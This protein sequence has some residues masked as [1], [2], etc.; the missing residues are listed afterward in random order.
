MK[1]NILLFLLLLC[2]YVNAQMNYSTKNKGAI[3]LF[4]KAMSAPGKALS[5][6]TGM[7]D[8]QAGVDLLT[9]ALIS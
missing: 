4:K 8:Y 2:G 3:K 9:K 5:P 1:R 7:P 6:E